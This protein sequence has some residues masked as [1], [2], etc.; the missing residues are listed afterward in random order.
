MNPAADDPVLRADH[1]GVAT[2]TLNRPARHN[3][4]TPALFRRLAAH[5]DDIAA[6]G[7]GIDLVVLRGAGR[8]FC[9]GHDLMEIG[10]ADMGWLRYE[11]MTLERFAR[12]PQM[13]VAAVHGHCLTGGLELALAADMIVCTETAVF[14]DTHALHDFVP[15]WG[16]TQRLP[17]RVG[18]ARALELMS[19]CRPVDGREAERIGLANLC[20][21]DEGLDAALERWAAGIR[22]TGRRSRAQIK[23]LVHETDGWRLGEGLAHELMRAP[24]FGD[25]GGRSNA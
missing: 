23:R 22:A 11:A 19:T 8:S 9:A 20:V 5:L 7:D 12:M 15:A 2:L 18:T 16:L 3:A 25:D 13:V 6:D 17:R 1:D 14:R 10:G 4:V 21:P 24:R